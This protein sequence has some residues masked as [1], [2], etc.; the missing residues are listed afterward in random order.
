[1]CQVPAA[2][3]ECTI[4]R[5]GRGSRCSRCSKK[6][7]G[8][9]MIDADA[10]DST[11]TP[12]EHQDAALELRRKMMGFIVSQAIAAGTDLGVAD[13]LREGRAAAP[14]PAVAARGGPDAPRRLLP[15]P[16]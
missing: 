1:M 3:P 9:P 16:V 2:Q 5:L 13:R 12:G 6:R 11:I 4:S 10:M 15:A 14:A 7:A 8:Y